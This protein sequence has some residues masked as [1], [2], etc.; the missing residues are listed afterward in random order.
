MMAL[1]Q[2]R[3][4][5]FLIH[6]SDTHKTCWSEV[7]H[8]LG[9]VLHGGVLVGEGRLVL[10]DPSIG[11]PLRNDSHMT[12]ALD[13]GVSKEQIEGGCVDVMI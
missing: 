4:D 2:G 9:Q 11:S 1:M 7:P 13:W 5:L 6:M 3:I 10:R 12:S 8:N